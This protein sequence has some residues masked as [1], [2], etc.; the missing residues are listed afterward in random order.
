MYIHIT[1]KNEILFQKIFINFKNYK[2][3]IA[4]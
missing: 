4:S 2:K 3:F 1:D